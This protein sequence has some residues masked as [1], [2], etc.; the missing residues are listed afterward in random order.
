MENCKSRPADSACGWQSA[1]GAVQVIGLGIA[2]SLPLG[3]GILISPESPRWL[4]GRGKWDEARMSMARLRGMKDDPYNQLVEDDFSE[5]HD[6]MEEQKSAGTGSWLELFTG[7]PGKVRVVYRTF[8]GIFIHFLQQW[9][10]GKFSP[11]LS[12]S[13]SR[14][15]S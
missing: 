11:D 2:F 4:A 10:G 1:D 3:L 15:Y 13:L 8:L 14:R 7:S 9:T 5:M 6:A 12:Y